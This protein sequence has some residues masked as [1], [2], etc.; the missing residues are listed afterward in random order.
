MAQR[1]NKLVTVRGYSAHAE[2]RHTRYPLGEYEGDGKLTSGDF[3]AWCLYDA[4]GIPGANVLTLG[5]SGALPLDGLKFFAHTRLTLTDYLPDF[6]ALKRARPGTRLLFMGPSESQHVS[7]RMSEFGYGVGVRE[8][9]NVVV[10][11]SDG[12]REGVDFD[13][14]AGVDLA[15]SGLGSQQLTMETTKR[16]WAS[17]A[18]RG[19]GVSLLVGVAG[20][21]D[22]GAAEEIEVATRFD[23]SIVYGVSILDDMGRFWTVS[24]T[25][26]SNDRRNLIYECNRAVVTNEDFPRILEGPQISHG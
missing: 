22:E 1:F 9:V 2:F 13:M 16:V 25:R 3:G 5:D 4:D 19:A 24:D 21:S 10:R 6:L 11:L 17:I 12:Q 26:T 15:L 14:T 23:P 7:Y 20:V 8:T 18:E